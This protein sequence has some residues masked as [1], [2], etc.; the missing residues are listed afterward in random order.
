[1]SSVPKECGD[2]CSHVPVAYM[3]AKGTFCVQVKLHYEGRATSL[4]I[5]CP[6]THLQCLGPADTLTLCG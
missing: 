6:E 3:D 4:E 5:G 2:F 1:M